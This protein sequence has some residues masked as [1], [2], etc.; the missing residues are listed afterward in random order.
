MRWRRAVGLALLLG[1]SACRRAPRATPGARASVSD[2]LL[3]AGDSLYAHAKYDSARTTWTQALERAQSAGDRHGQAAA[4]TGLGLTAWRMG[5]I[6][7]ARRRS[8]AAL[9]IKNELGPTEDLSKSY[10]ALGLIAL[11]E[12]RNEEAA[13][14]FNRAI[15]TARAANDRLGVA[16]ASGGL[17]NAALYLGDASRARE[18]QRLQRRLAHALGETVME[19]NALLNEAMVDIWEGDPHP[20]FAR[21]DT[22]RG[23]YRRVGAANR[24]PK[25][26]AQ[27]ATA[28]ELTGDLDRAFA[29]LDTAV[30]IAHRLRLRGEE[31]EDDRLLAELHLGIGDYRRAVESFD[32]TEARMRSAGNEAERGTALRG[33]A[34][35]H[36][37]LGNLRRASASAEEALRLHTTAGE[38]F[39]QLDDEL[40]LA[41]I[42]YRKAGVAQAE[43]QLR[44][45]FALADRLNTRGTRIAVALA[46]ARL[47]DVARNP[48][49]VLR[50]LRGAG[51]ELAAGDYGDD[52][53][54][55][56][57]TARAYA[58]LGE[59]D[60]AVAAGRRAVAAVERLRGALASEDVRATYIADRA[61]V[62]GDLVLALLRLGRTADAFAV[63]D[64]ARSREL[65]RQLAAARGEA[66]SGAL[67]PEL[68][69]REALLR[70]IDALV[71]QLREH[72]GGR[73]RERGEP[74]DSTDASLSSSL[75][76][77]RSEY[78]ALAIRLG[79]QRPRAALLLGA[80]PLRLGEVQA[81]LD[82]DEALLD[83]L[84]AS[85]RLLV[86]V[87]TRDSLRVVEAEL[88]APALVERVRLLR[89]L[90]GSPTRDWKWGLAAA[91][92]LHDELLAPVRNTGALRS[93]RRLLIVPHGVLGQVPFAALVDGR[94]GRYVI[95]DFTITM[96]PSAAS[97]PALRQ[98]PAPAT[99]AVVAEGL[100]PFPDELPATR[101]E[102]QAFR[103]SLPGAT[104]RLGPQATE[105]EV[106]R[107]LAG[108]GIVHV[109]THGV[110]NVRSPMFSRIELA[111]GGAE[112]SQD[113]GR[114]EV[115]E[116]LDL[117]IRS[118]LVFLSGCETGAGQEWTDDPVR[119]AAELTLAQAMLTAGAAN[120]ILTLW[121][122]DDAGAAVFAGRFY[123]GLPRQPVAEALAEAQRGMA[124]NA[125]YAS[126]YYWAGYMLSGAGRLGAGPQVQAATSVSLN[127]GASSP[128]SDSRRSRP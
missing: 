20:A 28:Y 61:N 62:Y 3:A 54:T 78:E 31:D 38:R 15:E 44:A 13:R 19:G 59:L 120:V 125:R 42:D 72:E 80:D 106:R 17:G 57:L 11:E 87:V 14:S 4:L 111:R 50:A 2:S 7:E 116:L 9:A 65:L 34:D 48:A 110:L 75:A 86:F 73:R 26:L 99:W 122:I 98:H 64:Q 112:G 55:N 27:L 43:P 94:T 1:V 76:A 83:Y 56:A 58:R 92:A 12:D 32:A 77:A 84:I 81:S 124:I 35:A 109:A 74:P 70:R 10:N 36:F 113:D 91:R 126:P 79:Q 105:A 88:D 82:P 16:R 45:A 69:Q 23:L 51:P 128:S 85:D 67:T 18:N 24:D 95:E 60:S 46:E 103:A 5:D 47:A 102:L 101:Q 21:L 114:L 53:E 96:L 63:A 49:R 104:L 22:A 40:L 52:W 8:E 108:N 33:S 118:P 123:E 90:W 29:A 30:A 37:R 66:R 107:A 119:G 121:R 97:L 41:Q 93:V 6:R 115:H 117:T 127:T 71:Q 39:E 89:D 100:A 25:A 68:I